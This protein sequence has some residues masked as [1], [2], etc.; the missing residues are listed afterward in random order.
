[1][2]RNRRATAPGIVRADTE[3]D[4]GLTPWMVRVPG[5][6]A[7]TG[8]LARVGETAADHRPPTADADAMPLQ[9]GAAM[10]GSDRDGKTAIIVPH[11]R[12]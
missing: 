7:Q 8:Y 12:A 5:I 3:T 10:A 11:A 1:M 6:P 2:T 9:P 4:G